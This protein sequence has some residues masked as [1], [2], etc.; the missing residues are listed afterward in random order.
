MDVSCSGNRRGCAEGRMLA[1][2]ENG[3]LVGLV[4]KK[5]I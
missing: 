1:T 3:L 4:R 2:I 5:L